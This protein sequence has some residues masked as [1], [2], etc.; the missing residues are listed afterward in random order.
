M[1]INIAICETESPIAPCREPKLTFVKAHVEGDRHLELQ[2]RDEVVSLE[3]AAKVMGDMEAFFKRN[4]INPESDA[5]YLDK[6]KKDADREALEPFKESVPTGWVNLKGLDSEKAEEVYQDSIKMDAVTGWM[7][8]GFSETAEIC[9]GCPLSWDKGRGCMGAFGP[10]NSKLPGIAEKAGCTIVAS[11]PE[12]AKEGKRY[13]KED[14]P[15]LLKEVEILRPALVADSKMAVHRYSGV[16]DRLEAA[17]NACIEGEC[18][19][20]FF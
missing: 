4:R 15:A 8:V 6:V 1:G 12:T 2:D 11:V 14:A 9:S 5:I 17:A 18:G 20:Y 13:P 10:D 19:F 3:D 16:L 7:E